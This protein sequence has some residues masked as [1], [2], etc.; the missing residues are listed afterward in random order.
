MLDGRGTADSHQT[1][2]R[3]DIDGLRAV[4]VLSV[5][6]YHLFNKTLPGGFLG[7][8]IFFVISGYLITNVI[9]RE[10]IHK[11]FSI[12]RFY[13]RRV[14]RIM[15]AVLTV[16]IAASLAAIAVLLPMD[17][18]GYAKSVFASLGF[19]A[20]IYFW[21]DTNYFAQLAEEK[22]L[23][24]VWSLGVEEQFYIIFPL[25]VVLCVR[26]RRSVLLPLTAVLVLLSLAANIFAVRIG[27]G[28][29][30]F[31]LLPT[32]AWEIGAGALL[33]LAPATKITNPWLRHGIGAA[34][35]ALLLIGLCLR[36]NQQPA[37]GGVIPPALWAVAGTTMAIYLGKAGGSWFTRFLSM[38]VLVWIGLISYSLYLWH[39]PILVLTRYYLVRTNLSLVETAIV[40]A[41]MFALAWGSWDYIER[42]FRNRTMPIGRVLAWVGC[43]CLVV[44]LGAAAILVG[45]G[46]PSRFNV[47]AARI[48]AAV[49]TGYRCNMNEYIPFGGSRG[50][51]MSMPS[52][53]PKDASVAL[54]GN[55]HAQMYAPLVT[56][57]LR[58]NH[59]GGILVP[60]NSCLPMPDFNESST[61]MNLAAKNLD[62]VEKLPRIRVVILAMTWGPFQAMYTPARPVPDESKAKF[63]AEGL[64]RLI[65]SLEQ[66]GKTVVL[67]GPVSIPGYDSASIVGRQLGFGH[68]V[69]EPLFSPES[70]FMAKQGDTIAHFA[71]RNDIIF[72]RPD[73]IQCQQGRCDYFRGG[74][75]LFADSNHIAEAA[76]PLFR[77]VFQPAL[78]R[79]FLITSQSK[80]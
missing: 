79:A 32:R 66:H 37:L 56:D 61:C 55:S 4:A 60:L 43:G 23:L 38:P 76:L 19:V 17:L 33:A 7:V 25:F 70:T 77:P 21:R 53:D 47:E 8:D 35:S 16:L 1:G 11:N 18:K 27:G 57:I 48:N 80:L 68:K 15:P 75:S 39:W 12:A 63:F 41:L 42:P 72:V 14:R 20:N 36:G 31:Y 59:R 24:H 64:D 62:A 44:A 9:W 22:P 50:C 3:S 58:Q 13:E 78:Q 46:F 2:Y 73:R 74:S 5:I 54:I 49:G 29:P 30:A 45:K 67:V 26:W 51:L 28:L 6:A 65:E 40:V 10:A 34:A 69:V 71:S 52:R